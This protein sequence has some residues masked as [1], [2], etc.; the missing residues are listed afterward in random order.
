MGLRN[1][2]VQFIDLFTVFLSCHVGPNWNLSAELLGVVRN[3][4][5]PTGELHCVDVND[6]RFV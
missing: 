2:F 3:Q 5:L 6:A 1:P 4:P